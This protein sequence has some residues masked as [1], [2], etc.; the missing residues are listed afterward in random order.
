MTRSALVTGGAG[1]IG[2]HLVDALLDARRSRHGPRRPLHRPL[3][4]PRRRAQPRR[5]LPPRERH[6]RRRRRRASFAAARPDVVLPPRGAD[7]RPPRG[8]RPGAR[9]D[10][11]PDRHGDDARRGAAPRRPRAS[12]WPRPAARSTATPTSVPTPETAAPRPASPYAASKA[13]AESYLELYRAAARALD[14]QRCGWPTSTARARPAAR[15]G[16]IAIF[17]AAAAAGDAVT[18]YGDGGQTRDFVYVGDVV[19]AFL[20]AGERDG[21]GLLQHRHGPRDERAR[22]SRA[23]SACAPASSPS[24]PARCS[25]P[26]SIRAR[27]R[28]AARLARAHAAARRAAAHAHQHGSRGA[29]SSRRLR[30]AMK[31]GG[32]RRR[33]ERVRRELV[34]DRRRPP[35]PRP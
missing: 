31:P 4:E 15:P 11:Q 9:R 28:A 22:R 3:G 12:C 2:S 30:I 26:A 19:D 13:A 29:S 35:C 16:V 5:P 27:R 32:S 18:I 17:C 14:V 20:A 7:R 33:A 24:A 34:L 10:G 25:A 23:R 1:F 21:G 6:R 8:R